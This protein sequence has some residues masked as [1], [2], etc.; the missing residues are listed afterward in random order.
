MSKISNLFHCFPTETV[1]TSDLLSEKGYTPQLMQKYL[2]SGWVKRIGDGAYCRAHETVSF[3]GALWPVQ[4]KHHL[5]VCGKSALEMQGHEHYLTFGKRI[6]QLSYVP[7]FTIPKW[8]KAYDFGVEFQF[9]RSATIPYHLINNVRVGTVT[10]QTSCLELAAFEACHGIP[11]HNTFDSVSAI[12]DSL[13]ALRVD[14]VQHLLESYPSFKAKRLFLY[15]ATQ[16]QHH[17]LKKINTTDINLGTGKR[18]IIKG[19]KLDPTFLITVP[20][21]QNEG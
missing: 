11:K 6:I 1:L 20:R 21:I 10:I 16:A 19:G 4:Q 17:W 18:Q 3:Q 8:I 5:I 15:F 9:I 14:V 7:G 13:T 12:F 2:K